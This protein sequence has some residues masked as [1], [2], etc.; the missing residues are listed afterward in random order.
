[1]ACGFVISVTPGSGGFVRECPGPNVYPFDSIDPGCLNQPG[2]VIVGDMDCSAAL[3]RADLIW[4]S[5]DVQ[6]GQAINVV[7][8]DA[9]CF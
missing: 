6:G 5:F 4:V 3:G 1:M 8:L 9:P 7:C 2:K